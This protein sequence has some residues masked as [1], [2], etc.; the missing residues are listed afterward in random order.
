MLASGS[1]LNAVGCAGLAYT[2]HP[3]DGDRSSRRSA[4]PARELR[5]AGSLPIALARG[6]ISYSI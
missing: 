6:A 3:V 2:H 5:A 4:M 1:L